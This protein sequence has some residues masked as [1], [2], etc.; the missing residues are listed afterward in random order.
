MTTIELKTSL[1]AI[2][3]PMHPIYAQGFLLPKVALKLFRVLL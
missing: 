2:I 1:L 3:M